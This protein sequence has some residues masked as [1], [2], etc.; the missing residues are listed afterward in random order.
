MRISITLRVPAK[1]L[2]AQKVIDAI[3]A[4]QRSKTAPDVIHLFKTTTVGWT[5]PPTWGQRQT[6]SRNSIG[7][8][9][10][11]SGPNSDQYALVNAGAKRH[12]INA[13]NAPFLR[14]RKGYSASTK[15]RVLSSKAYVRSGAWAKRISVNHPGFAARE[16]DATIADQYSDT[17]REDMQDAIN[18]AH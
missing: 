18:S 15:P 11:S 1:V 10:H 2:D 9:V 5:H 4:K 6:V 16:F 8:E 3:A 14:Y 12:P 17:F 13:R 7:M